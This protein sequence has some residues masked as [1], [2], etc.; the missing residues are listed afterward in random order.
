MAKEQVSTRTWESP[1]AKLRYNGGDEELKVSIEAA[2]LL[3]TPR[4]SL[5]NVSIPFDNDPPTTIVHN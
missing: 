2:L 4:A 1:Q 5:Q 3:V